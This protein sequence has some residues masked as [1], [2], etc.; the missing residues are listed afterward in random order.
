MGGD[1]LG[2]GWESK[3]LLPEGHLYVEGLEI[4]VYDVLARLM[5]TSR[6]G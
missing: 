4:L 1:G 3:S 6:G 2:V 5:H